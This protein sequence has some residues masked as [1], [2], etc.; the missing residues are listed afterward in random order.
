[1]GN[2]DLLKLYSQLKEM[3]QT[4]EV[5]QLRKQVE[6]T[7]Y[8]NLKFYHLELSAIGGVIGYDRLKSELEK[9]MQLIDLVEQSTS[10]KKK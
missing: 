7:L 4:N 10:K 5:K 3:K 2:T 9:A 1:M 8:Y 6:E